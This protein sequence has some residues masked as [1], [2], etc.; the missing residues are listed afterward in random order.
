MGKYL[1]IRKIYLYLFS[2]VGL[3]MMII[4]TA[5][6]VDLGLKIFIFKQADQEVQYRSAPPYPIEK[7]I[8]RQGEDVGIK[9]ENIILTAEEKQLLENWKN[10]YKRWKEEQGK[11]DYVRS[12]R[13]RQASESIAWIIVGL[14]L[15]LYH[16]RIIKKETQNNS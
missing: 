16:W 7:A 2:L 5:R 15:Y 4:G 3:F 14:P 11:I 1:L 12:N 9:T 13:E 8:E 6:L 10:D